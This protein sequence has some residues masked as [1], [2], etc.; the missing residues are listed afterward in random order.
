MEFQTPYNRF[1]SPPEINGGRMITE[2][3]GY[4]P[5][6]VQIENLINAGLRL[7]EYRKEQYDFG[8]DEPDDDSFADPTR[9][10]N[11][12]LADATAD[13][14]KVH[15]AFEKAKAL[16]KAE[17]AAKA[18]EEAQGASTTAQNGPEKAPPEESSK[19]AEKDG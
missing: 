8:A 7:A 9:A 19:G 5:A 1:P 13:A 15:S 17:E 11:Y 10:P 4:V 3:A 6:K 2:T 14:R 12:D 18:E 16:K